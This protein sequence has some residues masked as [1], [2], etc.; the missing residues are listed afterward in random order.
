[1]SWQSFVPPE[2]VICSAVLTTGGEVV[3]GKRHC[4]CFREIAES[5]KCRMKSPDGQG[6]VTS[7][8]R[9]VTRRGGREIQDA[10]GIQSVAQGGYRGDSLYSEDLY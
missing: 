7:L 5:G 8:G 9:Y 3:I 4:D 6:F 10:A 1:M 2:T